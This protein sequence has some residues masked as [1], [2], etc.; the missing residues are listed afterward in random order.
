MSESEKPSHQFA[1]I[2]EHLAII[3]DGNGRWAKARGKSAPSGHKAGVET[4]RTVLKL[5]KNYGIKVVTLFAFSSENWLRP[6]PEVKALMLLF[7]T[8]LKKEV[9]QLNKDGVRVRFIG[10][11]QRFTAGLLKQMQYAEELTAHNTETTLVIAVDYGGQW[12]IANAAKQ[13]ALQVKAG[14]L[15]PSAIDAALLGE[16]IALADLPKPDLCLRTSGEQRISNFLLW[17]LAYA[18]LYFTDTLWPDFT[19]SDMVQMLECY[20]NRD[21]RFGGREDDDTLPA[22]GAATPGAA[23]C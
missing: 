11:R 6:G 13:L 22:Q 2:P 12:D 5:C 3:M 7:S 8:Y 1:E 15:D 17:Q 16:H 23:S 19:D 18:E 21:R 20:N 4:V 10:D 9:K 14:E